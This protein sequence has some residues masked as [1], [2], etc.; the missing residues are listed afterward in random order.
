MDGGSTGGNGRKRS[1]EDKAE[2]VREM[3]KGFRL[4][5]AHGESYLHCSKKVNRAHSTCPPPSPALTILLQGWVRNT[6]HLRQE[7]KGF[8]CACMAAGSS[9]DG[10]EQGQLCKT[11]TKDKAACNSEN[12]HGNYKESGTQR[13]GR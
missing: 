7:N 9:S 12:C 10:Q 5:A 1:H 8:N 13:Q 11:A 4:R 3:A 2:A 6:P